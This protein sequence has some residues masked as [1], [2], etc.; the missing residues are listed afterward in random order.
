MFVAFWDRF[1]SL[2]LHLLAF[3]L[4]YRCGYRFNCL[5]VKKVPF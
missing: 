2:R 5:L 3:C 4:V 1:A